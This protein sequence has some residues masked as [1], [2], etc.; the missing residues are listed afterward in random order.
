[1]P[2]FRSD[3]VE[4]YLFRRRPRRVEFLALRRAKGRLAGVWQPVT[5][6]R[7][8]GETALAAARR[9][10]REETGFLP[11]RWWR[12]E[13]MLIF[14]G[15]KDDAVHF[16]P[17][18]VAE[19]TASDRVRISREH[20]AHAFLTAAA[21]GRRYL[22]ASQRRAL[23]AVRDQI[24]RGGRLERT[25]AIEPDARTTARSVKART[26]RRTRRT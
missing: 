22:W 19:V 10:V 23:A 7:E 25:L 20:D 1:V 15:T 8:R 21:A 9:E 16:V 17:R 18:F 3:H 14:H 2:E 26:T 11:R 4:V 12:L 13:D 5:G 6:T 24:L